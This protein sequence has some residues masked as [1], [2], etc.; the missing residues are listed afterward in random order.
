MPALAENRT[1]N[2][3]SREDRKSRSRTHHKGEGAESNEGTTVTICNTAFHARLSGTPL[4]PPSMPGLRVAVLPR[5]LAESHVDPLRRHHQQEHRER[6]DENLK[7]MHIDTL[8]F[9]LHVVYRVGV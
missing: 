3:E 6:G 5:A 2:T 4:L 7:G 1:S 8:Y 9:N